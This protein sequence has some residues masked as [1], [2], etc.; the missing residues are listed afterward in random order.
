MSSPDGQPYAV[1]MNFG[2][3]GRTVYFHCAREGRKLEVIRANPRAVL[4]VAESGPPIRG[5][6]ACAT[7]LPYRSVLAFGALREV[8]SPAE[9]ATGLAAICR[10]NGV[11]APSEG[12]PGWPAFWTQAGR[13]VVLAL[14]IEHMTVKGR[15]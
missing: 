8:S 1:P 9:K 7:S 5:E 13:T 12:Q 11:N 4:C 10:A 14:E 2:R 15:P 3:D 6:T